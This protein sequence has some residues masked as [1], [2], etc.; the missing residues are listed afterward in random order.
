MLLAPCAQCFTWNFPMF[1]CCL[2][3]TVFCVALIDVINCWNLNIW[4]HKIV[5][6]E[7]YEMARHWIKKP[8]RQVRLSIDLW[9]YVQIIEY[10][11][12]YTQAKHEFIYLS[13]NS[14]GPNYAYYFSKL[15]QDF[16]ECWNFFL[17]AFISTHKSLSHLLPLITW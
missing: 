5:S 2:H 10:C 13:C 4:W 17:R 14:L 9:A 12:T 7:N 8:I 11:C 1:C 6:N 3:C 16:F 15:V